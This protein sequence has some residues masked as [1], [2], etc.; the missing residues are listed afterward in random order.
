MAS[1]LCACPDQRILHPNNI[2]SLT[3]KIYFSCMFLITSTSIRLGPNE[4]TLNKRRCKR[5]LSRV[6]VHSSVCATFTYT[7]T[8]NQMFY[9]FINIQFNGFLYYLKD[10]NSCIIDL[11][12]SNYRESSPNLLYPS[13][14][15]ISRVFEAIVHPASTDP[16]LRQMLNVR[17]NNSTYLSR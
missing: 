10:D 15:C 12:K 5:I 13:L 8:I 2:Y 6:Y 1:Y 3:A 7:C 11:L 4:K 14:S 17:F 16:L 9:I